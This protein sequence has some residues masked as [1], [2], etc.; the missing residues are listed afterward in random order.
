MKDILLNGEEVP[1]LTLVAGASTKE[2]LKSKAGK[3][4]KKSPEVCDPHLLKMMPS[5]T[6]VQACHPRY[7][8]GSGRRVKNSKLVWATE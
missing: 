8:G 6:A 1:L 4:K 2:E 7:S 3:K 5:N